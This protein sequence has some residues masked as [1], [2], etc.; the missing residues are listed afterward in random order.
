MMEP[1][2]RAWWVALLAVGIVAIYF[3]VSQYST[4]RKD[5][6]LLHEGEL[7]QAVVDSANGVSTSGHRQKGNAF[8]Q[9]SYDYKGRS[10]TGEGILA[11]RPE[12]ETIFVKR[13]VP[14]RVDPD[15]PAVWT[16]RTSPSSLSTALVAVWAILPLVLISLLGG[17][18]S[19]MRLLRLVRNGEPHRAVVVDTRHVALAPRSRLIRCTL[20]DG[21]DTRIYSVYVPRASASLG[22]GDELLISHN[23]SGKAVAIDWFA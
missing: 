7:I 23:D 18:F 8:V 3:I 6:R 2:V 4:W 19:T 20:A 12:T 15:D 11:G 17:W 22:R 1:R 21:R 9:L 13:S 14:I 16:A 5:N 10:Y